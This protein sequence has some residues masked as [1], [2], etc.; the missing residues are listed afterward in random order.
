MAMFF[1]TAFTA[2]AGQAHADGGCRSPIVATSTQWKAPPRRGPRAL[3]LGGDAVFLHPRPQLRASEA[4]QARGL[5]LVVAGTGECVDDHFA[6]RLYQR[7]SG[8][9]R[10]TRCRRM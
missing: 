9:Q 2:A 1:C 4:E 6:F 5:R 3:A 8:T 10:K 7:T